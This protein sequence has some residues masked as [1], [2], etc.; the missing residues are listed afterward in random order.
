MCG[1]LYELAMPIEAE[2]RNLYP[3]SAGLFGQ[4]GV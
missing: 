1:A 3:R 2:P 4:V